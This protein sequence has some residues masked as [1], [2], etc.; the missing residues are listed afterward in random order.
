[1]YS[2]NQSINQYSYRLAPEHVF[3]AAVDDSEAAT[4][5]FI[6]HASD[7]GVDPQRVAVMGKP[8]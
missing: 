5:Y 1:M 6:E 4:Q 8:Y 3:P 2:I 7:Y